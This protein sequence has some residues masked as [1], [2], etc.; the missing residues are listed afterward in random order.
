MH[1][2][3]QDL[4]F[5]FLFC[6]L[7]IL[8]SQAFAQSTPIVKGPGCTTAT[9]IDWDCDGYGPGSLLGPDADDQDATVNTSI[10]ALAKYGTTSAMLSHLGYNPQRRLYIATNGSNATGQP[11]NEAM[12]YASWLGVQGILQPGDAVIWR[13][14]KYSDHPY[15][16]VSGTTANPIILMAYPGEKVILDQASNGIDFVSQSNLTFDGLILQNTATN[17]G[18]GMFFGDPAVNITIRNMELTKRGRGM[19]GMNGLSNVL[20]E[21]NVIHDTTEEHCIYLGA[22]E[23]PDTNVTIKNNLIYNGSYNGIQFNGRVT[24]L[25]V[26]SNIIYNNLLSALS[27]L[28]GVSNSTIKNNLMF[29]NGRN[30]MLIW[31]YPGDPNQNIN[32]YDQNNDTF[33]NNTCYVGSMD[34]TGTGISQPAINIDN[35]GYNV[36]MNNHVFENNVFVTQGYAIFKFGQPL[37]LSTA[38]I[39]NNVM[40]NAGGSSYV[41]YN[42]TDYNFSSLNAWDS[43][44]GGNIQADPLFKAANTAWYNTAGNFDF[45]LQTGSPAIGMS[46]ASVAP[47][48][49]IMQHSRG[50]V[51]DAGAYQHGSSGGST[52]P[53]PPPPP[54]PAV[55]LSTLHCAASTLASGAATTCTATLS[56]AAPSGGATVAVS[57]NTSA[58]TVPTSV[59][60]ASGAASATFNATAGTIT[61]NQTATIT[62]SLNG[63]SQSVSIALTAPVV[64]PA[65]LSSLQCSAGSLASGASTICTATLSAKAA[66]AT[67]VKLSSST[68]LLAIPASVTIASGATSA[69]FTAT[70]G[71]IAANTSA[72]VTAT[73]NSASKIVSLSLTAPVV[74]PPPPPPSPVLSSLACA[75]GSVA[76]GA[77]TTCTV[78][79]SASASSSMSVAL[80]SSASLLTVPAS[81]AVASGKASATFSA[82]AGTCTST[83]N[84]TITAS[85]SGVSKTATVSVQSQVTTP[86]PPPAS[87]G[88]F[89]LQGIAS[90][91]TSKTTGAIVTPTS[92]PVPLT[93][94]LTVRGTGSVNF[95]TG[96]GVSFKTGGQQNANTAFYNFKGTQLGSIFNVAQGQ[97]S[98]NL[99]SSYTFTQRS[100]LP[101]YNYR[102]VL[103]VFDN[104]KEMF[105][106][107]SQAIWGRLVFYYNMGGTAGQY[108][109]VPQGQEDQL[110]GAGK[111]LNV[112]LAWDGK[113]VNLYLNG[114]L[115]NSAPY[116]KAT[117]NWT[118][119]S[120]FTLGANDTHVYGGGYYS[121]DDVISAFQVK[122]TN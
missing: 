27:F 31:D 74:V 39:R 82:S 116:T 54:P 110:F 87:T 115:V 52:P 108:Y 46:I 105:Y 8:G 61:S 11:N 51:P 84:A 70:A 65:A 40:L 121:C 86:P 41:N 62:A 4:F 118:S 53:P 111:T 48:Y 16:A 85:M 93:G 38:T 45:T 91:V 3:R 6:L 12:P 2:K 72:T 103:D 35:G 92:T 44:K 81:V 113:N 24:N 59:T 117:P 15:L 77:S 10:T 94:N 73:L 95:A 58:L 75:S 88:G 37:Y 98:F 60:V 25:V 56:A 78:T 102:E 71:T 5:L 63:V 36:N 42:N 50:S 104:S 101:N 17:L 83:S 20:I 76:S 19:L 106:F 119:T 30:C 32:P 79:L 89:S 100:A 107:E 97:M 109:Y 55:T 7:T 112:K 122:T 67:A 28:E 64:V 18:E 1:R 57:D 90:E 14:G 114:T 120:T 43:L 66:S 21:R 80:R 9:V 23:K 68:T 34:A 29:G 99:K 26:D 22:R 47:A 49:D 69:T 33:I 13:A 96:G